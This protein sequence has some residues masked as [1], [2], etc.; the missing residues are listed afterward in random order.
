MTDHEYALCIDAF[1]PETIPMARLAQYMTA[2]AEL[3]GFKET[4]HFVRIE[5]GSARLVSRV[6]QQDLPKVERRLATLHTLEPAAGL[7]KAFKQIDDLLAE[8]NA[9]AK[10]TSPKGAIIEFP[11][12]DRPRALSF[13]AFRQE[14]SID[15]VIVNI[16]GRDSTAHVILQDG[17]VNYSNIDLQRSTARELAKHLYGPKVRLYGS[18]RWERHPDGAWKLLSFKVDRYEVLDEAPLA[19]VFADVRAAMQDG[20]DRSRTAYADLMALRLGD[21]DVH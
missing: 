20:G 9:V 10:F 14:G 4:T 19:S 2:L 21:G 16:G 5:P 12:R 18:G 7:A 11:G 6:E 1:T 15:G 8:D 13:S 3:V 17:A